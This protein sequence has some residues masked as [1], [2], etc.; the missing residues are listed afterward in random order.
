[1]SE[2]RPDLLRE[3]QA[4]PVEDRIELLIASLNEEYEADPGHAE[5]WI[6]EIKRRI[7]EIDSGAATLMDWDQVRARIEERIR[8]GR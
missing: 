1:M 3:L 5:A 6:A 8:T 2:M 4:L 7:G